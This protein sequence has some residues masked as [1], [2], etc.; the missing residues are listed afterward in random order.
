MAALDQAPAGPVTI[1]TASAGSGQSSLVRAWADRRDE[2]HQP[3]IAQVQREARAILETLDAPRTDTGEIRNAQAVI[4]LAE[5]DPTADLTAAT[6]ASTE[7]RPPSTAPR[8]SKPR[9]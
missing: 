3:A 5:G 7:P 6:P 4:R 2:G 8:W 9:S 1:T